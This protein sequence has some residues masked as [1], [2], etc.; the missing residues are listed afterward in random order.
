MRNHLRWLLVWCALVVS[1]A[2]ADEVTIKRAGDYVVQRSIET[3]GGA[4]ITNQ[5]TTLQPG[6]SYWS[7]EEASWLPSS[8]QIELQENGAKLNA[9]AMKVRFAANHND[10]NGGL[11]FTL[12]DGR[13]IKLKTIGIALT[14]R[15]TSDSVWIGE[16]KDSN[17]LL[18]PAGNSITYPDAFSGCRADIRVTTGIGQFQSDVIL[19][20]RIAAP[21][22]FNLNPETTDLDVWHLLIES[23]TPQIRELPISRSGGFIDR[24][25]QLEFGEMI[26]APGTAFL[27]GTNG[28]PLSTAHGRLRVAKDFFEDPDSHAKYLIE[29]VPYA[30]AVVHL[31]YLPK[32]EEARVDRDEILK[33]LTR[34]RSMATKGARRKP[35][36]L[37]SN[38]EVLPAKAIDGRERKVAAIRRVSLSNEPG[39]MMDYTVVKAATNFTFV[40]SSTY[41]VT[42]AITLA[43]TTTIEGGTVVKF[44]AYTNSAP[45]INVNGSVVCNTTLYAPATFT[46]KDDNSIGDSISG[47]TGSPTNCYG[48]YHLLFTST[49]TT[50]LDIHD[51]H[52][53]FAYIGLGFQGT[54]SVVLA[55]VQALW[56]DRAIETCNNT[57]TIR[58]LLAQNATNVIAATNATV[59]AEQ[60]TAHNGSRV[61]YHSGSTLALKNALV[62]GIAN[63]SSNVTE[64][65]VT[66]LSSDAGVFQSVRAGA[67]YLAANSPYRKA[68]TT[69]ISA[70]MVALQKSLTTYPPVD[71]TIPFVG[72]EIIQPIAAR[73]VGVPDVGFG[74]PALDYIWSGLDVGNYTITL[75]NGVCIGGYGTP[76][77]KF[78]GSGS[79]ISEG[80]PH[81]LNR[82]VTYNSVQEQPQ[83][84]ITNL[85]FF[86]G[87]KVNLR[88]TEVSSTALNTVPI[89]P[90]DYFVGEFLVQDSLLRNLYWS[91][92]NFDGSG[93]SPYITI[94]NSV[95][96]RLSIS[97]TQGYDAPAYLD[98][99]LRNNYF[100]NCTGAFYH[101][102]NYY[103]AWNIH[104]N[105]VEGALLGFGEMDSEDP[106][107]YGGPLS[108][109]GTTSN[110]GYTAGWPLFGD[111]TY[112]ANLTATFAT[113][114]LGPYY[115]P[116][117]G[118]SSSLTNLVNTGSQTSASA[119][120]Y[121][122][123]TRVD[124]TKE[125]TT[126]VDIGFH[127]VAVDSN[128]IPIDTDGDGI[129]DYLE[130]RNGN[131]TLDSGEL[132]WTYAVNNVNGLTVF[133]PLQP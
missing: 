82:L 59:T 52:T 24:D 5:Y 81:R 55:N 96:E 32:R 1:G 21:E 49:N 45:V 47:S 103:G 19:R 125:G 51:I 102:G 4:S 75:T 124:Q 60:I 86:G 111:S 72:D 33:R 114:P 65:S 62:V 67:H 73:I 128:G 9:S 98:V 120:L 84:W 115:Y 12:P 97:W 18:D 129:A 104:D 132:A 106:P 133:T 20:E 74:Y 108:S 56:C 61:F 87:Y 90:G 8:D 31:N 99:N 121:H 130:D 15:S 35:T 113:G 26:F 116:I 94:K 14:D 27:L 119:G 36:S 53:R 64:T 44:N 38:S 6:I 68:G 101:W 13:A 42:N 93:K 88:F 28:V 17:G 127:Y 43:S 34:A 117:T 100:R 126:T 29:H 30:E 69:N 50:A 112:K 25:Q 95:L 70:V 7:D 89:N 131:G 122:Y 110:D 92:W 66:T 118:T 48:W 58:N 23:P 2:L 11:E 77:L 71:R 83:R 37:A 123:T 16:L 40:G 105:F 46:S 109:A 91:F 10:V 85:T 80:L 79:L 54:N 41:L 76:L 107:L 78:T 39:F 22:S 3:L 63:T 57:L